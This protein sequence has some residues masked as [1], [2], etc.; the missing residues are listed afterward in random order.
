MLLFNV[1]MVII[2]HFCGG[3]FIEVT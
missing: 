3:F 1:I 2:Y